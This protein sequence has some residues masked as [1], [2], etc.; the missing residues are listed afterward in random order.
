[1]YIQMTKMVRMQQVK[2]TL[3]ETCVNSNFFPTLSWK[4]SNILLH[5]ISTRNFEW[6]SATPYIFN[7]YPSNA[8]KVITI[9]FNMKE[10]IL[11][12]FLFN[13]PP[14]LLQKSE[15]FIFGLLRKS[16]Y[17]IFKPMDKN[18]D[19]FQMAFTS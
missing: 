9:F 19:F 8:S 6:Y 16:N 1:M 7:F 17:L 12:H 11:I 18:M 2:L 5:N 13:S 3:P 10:S 4:Y 14:S 15:A